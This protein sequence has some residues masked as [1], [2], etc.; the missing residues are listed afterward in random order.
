MEA[1]LGVVALLQWPTSPQ[2]GNAKDVDQY[3]QDCDDASR[4]RFSL[5]FVSTAAA[6]GLLL[7]ITNIVPV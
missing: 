3:Y 4:Q 2:F 5:P 1:A 7:L 6:I